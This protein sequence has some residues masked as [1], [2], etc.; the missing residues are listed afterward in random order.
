MR[1]VEKAEALELLALNR[2]A[3]LGDDSAGCVMCAL[4]TLADREPEAAE[5][6]WTNEHGVVWFDRFGTTAGHLRA[7]W[8]EREP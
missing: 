5:V 1:R 8:P 6:I 7:A 2:Q 4:V 3:L